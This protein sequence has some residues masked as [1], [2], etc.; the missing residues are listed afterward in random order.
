MNERELLSSLNCDRE[1]GKDDMK[2][3]SDLQSI[4]MIIYLYDIIIIF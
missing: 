2:G 1:I 4:R 3:I